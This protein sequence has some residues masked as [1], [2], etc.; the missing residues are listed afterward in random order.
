MLDKDCLRAPSHSS[1]Y[2][3]LH[4]PYSFLFALGSLPVSRFSA[5]FHCACLTSPGTYE[6]REHVHCLLVQSRMTG[7]HVIRIS[8]RALPLSQGIADIMWGHGISFTLKAVVVLGKEEAE[9][10][11]R[12][13]HRSRSRRMASH[14][15][16]TCKQRV[17]CP[18]V[19]M[20]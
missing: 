4:L 9:M 7:K 6:Q 1:Q 15:T 5:C 17:E 13:P 10:N 2:P 3:L 14:Y 20:N 16:S 19:Q 12:L 8:S 11:E 18:C